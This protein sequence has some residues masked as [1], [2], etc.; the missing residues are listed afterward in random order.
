MILAMLVAVPLTALVMAQSPLDEDLLNM[1]WEGQDALVKTFLEMGAD[2]D[3]RDEFGQT[4]LMIAVSQGHLDTVRVLVEGGADVN[5]NSTDGSTVLSFAD[6]GEIIKL[7]TDAGATPTGDMTLEAVARLLFSAIFYIAAFIYFGLFYAEHEE[8]SKFFGLLIA[9]G[10]FTLWA[11]ILIGVYVQSVMFALP[12]ALMQRG[13][14]GYASYYVADKKNRNCLVWIV[15]TTI[16]GPLFLLIVLYLP[17]AKRPAGA[18]PI[19][20][21]LNQETPSKMSERRSKQVGLIE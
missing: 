5:A 14:I 10:A 12:G 3:A 19:L 20:L 8:K 13:L 18:R 15:L 2:V 16:F 11:T 21:K 4:T 9:L 1:A 6:D 17:R 7:L